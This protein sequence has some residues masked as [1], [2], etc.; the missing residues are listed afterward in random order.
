MSP[1]QGVTCLRVVS[2]PRILVYTV[3]LGKNIE[4]LR[5]AAG[6][7]NA[8]AFARKIGVTSPTLNDW[9]SGRYENLRLESLL[10]LAKGIPCTIE[11]L[12]GGVDNQYD[13]VR[14]DLEKTFNSG[15]ASDSVTSPDTTSAEHQRRPVSGG[16]ISA[17]TVTVHHSTQPEDRLRIQVARKLFR[18]ANALSALAN[19]LVRGFVAGQRP[20]A[21]PGSNHSAGASGHGG[22]HAGGRRRKSGGHGGKH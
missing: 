5:K 12:L 18:Q 17:E 4:Q 7:D 9:E 21:T 6:H 2:A 22:S 20:R 3:R 8:A 14:S 19:D 10:R 11:D 13:K 1:L 16:P 15:V